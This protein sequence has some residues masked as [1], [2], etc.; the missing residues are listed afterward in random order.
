MEKRALTDPRDCLLQAND[1]ESKKVALLLAE[2]LHFAHAAKEGVP[3]ICS[4][5]TPVTPGSSVV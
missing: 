1:G 2:A 3:T 5:L 4:G